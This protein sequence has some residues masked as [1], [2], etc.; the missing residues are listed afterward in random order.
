MVILTDA[1]ISNLIIQQYFFLLR[2]YP[3]VLGQ[4]RTLTKDIELSGYQVLKGVSITSASK[5]CLYYT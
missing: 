1:L 5:K 3:I 2:M 4:T